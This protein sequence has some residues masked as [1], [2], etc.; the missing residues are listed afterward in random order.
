MTK[1][2][3]VHPEPVC[4]AAPASGLRR[5][6]AEPSAAAAL[7]E[8]FRGEAKGAALAAELEKAVLAALEPAVEAFRAGERSEDIL[9]RVR[10]HN[11]SEVDYRRY[12]KNAEAFALAAFF[13]ATPSSHTQV[14]D[15]DTGGGGE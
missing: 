2:E 10:Q 1:Q 8:W 15:R 7:A 4:D 9:R 6:E 13:L 14:M 5:G 3:G 12:A 11:T